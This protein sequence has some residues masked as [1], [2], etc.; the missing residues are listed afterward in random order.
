MCHCRWCMTW[1]AAAACCSRAVSVKQYVVKWCI[2]MRPADVLTDAHQMGGGHL[3]KPQQ[4]L[5]IRDVVVLQVQC[6]QLCA[7]P[8]RRDGAMPAQAVAAGLQGVQAGAVLHAVEADESVPGHV[9]GG[10]GGDLR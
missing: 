1:H 8:H 2:F 5:G 9:E 6:R 10:H 4:T 7:V 3:Q